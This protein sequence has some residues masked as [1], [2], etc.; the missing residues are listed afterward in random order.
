M[1]NI[2]KYV[3]IA[4]I[5]IG[6]IGGVIGWVNIDREDYKNAKEVNEE[7]YN[8][9]FAEASYTTAK[10]IYLSNVS[11]VI[12]PTIVLIIGGLLIMGLGKMIELQV[13]ITEKLEESVR[14]QRNIV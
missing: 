2:F 9:E 7:L 4:L 14:I 12:V 1:E 13:R 10:S 8:N 11:V 5:A 3:G 6:V